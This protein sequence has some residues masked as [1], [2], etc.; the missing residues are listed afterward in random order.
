MRVVNCSNQLSIFGARGSCCP[1]R[2][3]CRIATLYGS[4]V[5]YFRFGS[6]KSNFEISFMSS[7]TTVVFPHFQ[8][9]VHRQQTHTQ[10]HIDIVLG[11]FFFGWRADLP[12]RSARR[13]GSNARLRVRAG[14]SPRKPPTGTRS[15]TR[16]W[17]SVH[18][19]EAEREFCVRLHART[20]SIRG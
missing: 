5:S 20:T 14:G 17:R 3:R 19:V 7:A 10:E 12:I 2:R 1:P 13:G 9:H 16:R 18:S 11:S 8:I 4:I 15:K 6:L